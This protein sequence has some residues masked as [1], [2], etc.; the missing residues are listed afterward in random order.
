MR[1]GGLPVFAPSRLLSTFV[2]LLLMCASLPLSAQIR[3]RGG[4]PSPSRG[5]GGIQLEVQVTDPNSQHLDMQVSLELVSSGNRQPNN[6]IFTNTDGRGTFNVPGAGT[7]QVRVSGAFIEETTTDTF[8]IQPGEMVHR[9]NIAVKVI[10]NSQNQQAAPGTGPTISAAQLNVPEKARKEFEKGMEAM[11]KE[12]WKKAE[13]HLSK[14]A[15]DYPDYDW[16]YNSLGVAYMKMGEKEKARE[17]FTHAIQIQGHNPQAERNLARILL[18][19]GEFVKAEQLAKQSLSM[20]PQDPDGLT[21]ES[22]AQLK[23][24]KYDEALTAARRVHTSEKHPFS[25]SHIIAGHALEA[26]NMKVEAAAE[27]RTFL[28]ESPD[29][30]E[31]AMAKRGLERMQPPH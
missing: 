14:A 2:S 9:E 8:W 6:R 4:I 31:A 26:K 21:L 24:G 23:E 30:P 12:E 18:I 28:A 1:Y 11:Q 17:S 7:Y 25:F 10:T 3:T 27:Y 19:D 5:T 13:E 16:A 15:R 29:A 22:Y 20:Q